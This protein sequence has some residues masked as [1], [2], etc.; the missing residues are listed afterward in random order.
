MKRQSASPGKLCRISFVCLWSVSLWLFVAAATPIPAADD[1]AN[2][3]P[4][5]RVKEPTIPN[6]IAHLTDFAQLAME[7]HSTRKHLPK[8]LRHWHG[9]AVENL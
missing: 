5:S 2:K 8:P 4:L 7:K 1:A 9:M 3:F 6:R